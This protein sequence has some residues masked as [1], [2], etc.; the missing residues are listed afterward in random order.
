MWFKQDRLNQLFY[1]QGAHRGLPLSKEKDCS[2][3]T[4]RWFVVVISLWENVA[5]LFSKR[6]LGLKFFL[7]LSALYSRKGIFF[8]AQ[9]KNG[10][11]CARA[12]ASQ[13]K[14]KKEKSIHTVDC[15]YINIQ[16][17]VQCFSPQT[18]IRLVLMKV[19]EMKPCLT[20]TPYNCNCVSEMWRNAN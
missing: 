2:F 10:Q 14:K 9:M 17:V 19:C 20:A 16:L 15:L 18:F 1:I 8:L 6:L 11:V 3:L 13:K 5:I 12:A 7:H 4:H